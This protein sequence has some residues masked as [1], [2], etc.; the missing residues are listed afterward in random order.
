MMANNATPR[1]GLIVLLGSGE[2]LPSSG[3]THE[4]VAQQLPEAPNIRIV[5]TPAG[6]EPN[7]A[8]VAGK[9]KT[10]IERRLQNYDPNVK[11]IP[12]RKQ[13]TSHSPDNVTIVKDL[14]YADE[15]MFGPG[16]PTYCA[17]QLKNTAALHITAARHRLG[18]TLFLSSASTLAFGRF[19]MPVYEIY[20]VGQDLHWQHGL[21]F[22]HPLGLDFSVIPHWNN[23]DGGDNL[24]TSR[25]YLGQDRFNALY[26]MLPPEHTILGIDEHTSIIID[27]A[28]QCCQVMGHGAVH[29]IRGGQE[30]HFTAEAEFS[31]NHLGQW[32]RPNPI[33]ANIPDEIWTQAVTINEER[34]TETVITPPDNVI[35][36]VNQRQQARQQKEWAVADQLRDQITNLGWQV[37]DTPQGPEITP[38]DT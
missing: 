7:T 30:Q 15:I 23:N 37:A 20:K 38:L 33:S 28:H 8:A 18:A 25:C 29:I 2:T 9:I 12:A 14:Y 27:L 34:Q 24:D 11:L 31:L 3:K 10:F 6:F 13:G 32:Q 17:R 22:W 4:Y 1:P 5:E 21:N 19:T 16:S 36:L 35:D 26:A